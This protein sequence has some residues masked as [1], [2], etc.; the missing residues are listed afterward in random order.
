MERSTRVGSLSLDDFSFVGFETLRPRLASSLDQIELRGGGPFARSVEDA[1]FVPAEQLSP[2]D[3]QGALLTGDGGPIPEATQVRRDSL[4]GDMLIGGLSHPVPLDPVHEVDE[5]VVYLGWFFNH[6]GHFLL[7]ST[8]RMWILEHIEPATKLVF[9]VLPP[10]VPSGIF[11]ELLELYGVAPDRIL[12]P[13]TQTRFRRVI[14]PEPLYEMSHAVHERMPALHRD[15]GQR[16]VNEPVP[17][18]QPVYLSRRL[19]PPYHR[20]IIG[21]LALEEILRENGFAVAYPET[22]TLRD[23]IRLINRHREVVTPNGSPTYLSLF[24]PNPPRLHV[25]TDGIPF[26]DY[27]MV[28]R[29]IG[30]TVT[31]C[32]VMHGDRPIDQPCLPLALDLEAM[33]SYLDSRGMIKRRVRSSL[34]PPIE[35]QRSDFEEMLSY[36][37]LKFSHAREPLAPE[38]EAALDMARRSWPVSWMLVRYF[39]TRDPDRVDALVR[40][41]TSLVLQERDHLR[42][43]YFAVDVS[44][45]PLKLRKLCQPD[46]FNQFRSA[47]LAQFG[48]ELGNPKPERPKGPR[49]RRAPA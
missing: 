30:A 20:R 47:I 37:R 15:I 4:G 35:Q 36:S 22:M 42:L 6:F 9:H 44:P 48:I 25:M 45:R 46:T 16:L 21:E 27:F 2:I 10:W 33:T 32:N 12:L 18:D 17:F 31:Y 34:P 14:V 49:A 43:A 23:Q 38:I 24:A 19:L 28:P 41:F 8:V 13:E 3:F 26:M 40:Q 39:T 7:E 1:I 11:L 29:A 5:E